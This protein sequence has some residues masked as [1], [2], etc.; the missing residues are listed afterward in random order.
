MGFR[1]RGTIL[2]PAGYDQDAQAYFNELTGT[3]PDSFKQAV[4]TFV[5]TLKADGTWARLDRLYLH[6]TPN[7][8]NAR[9]SIVNPTSTPITEVNSPTFTANFGI[10]GDGATSYINYNFTPSVDGVNYTLNSA[11]YF[12]YSRTNSAANVYDLGVIGTGVSQLNIRW[13]DGNFYAAINSAPTYGNYLNNPS[14]GFFQVNRVDSN[15]VELYKNGVL[16]A[17]STPN[18]ATNLPNI[19]YFGMCQNSG[20]VPNGFTNRQYSISGFGSGLINGATFNTAIQTL[21]TALGFNV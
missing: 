21:A 16:Q 3:I 14:T 5:L 17:T 11:S 19:S 4:N 13:G 18:A 10:N 6:A 2:K 7:Q 8:Q 9:I 20:G 1:R 12:M 15:R